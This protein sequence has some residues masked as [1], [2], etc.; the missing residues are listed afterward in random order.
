MR[1]FRDMGARGDRQ[2][3]RLMWLIEEMGLENFK[4]TVRKELASY[5]NT[6]N[7]QF[8]AAQVYD[9]EWNYGHR[10]ILVYIFF[11]LNRSF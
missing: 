8:E 7:F 2:K 5:K 1:I 11:L 4:E 3:T 6:D 10:D 9:Y